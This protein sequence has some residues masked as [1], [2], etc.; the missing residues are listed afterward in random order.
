MQRRR[1]KGNYKENKWKLFGHILRLPLHTPAN[2]SMKYYFK[3]PE[4]MKKYPRIPRT[5]L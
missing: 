2:K 1:N 4:K 3:V 5:T